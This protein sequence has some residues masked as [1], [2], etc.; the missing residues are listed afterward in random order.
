MSASRVR[1]APAGDGGTGGRAVVTGVGVVAPSGVGAD[2]HWR[3]VLSG[4]RRTGPISLFDATGYP[5]RLG[6]EVAD[7]DPGRYADNRA[8]VQT[9]R[10]THL[11]FAA[12]ALALADAGLPERATDPYGWAVTLASASGGNLFGQR[13][14]QRLWSSPSRTVG[15]YQSIAWF[16][17][18][19]VG[20]LSIRHQAKGPCGVL[21]AE[22]AGGLDSLAHA[23]RTVR[24]GASVVLAGATECPLSPYALACQLRSGLLSEVADPERAY[25]PFD[26]TASGYLPAEGGAVFVVEELEHA[27]ARGARSYGEVTGWGATHDAAHTTADSAGDPHQYA[28]A[29]RL[30]LGRAGVEPDEVDVVVPDAL[31][32]P[33]YDRAEASALRAVFGSRLPPVSTHKELTGRAHQGGSA[34]DVATALLAF[35]HDTL[36]A[37]AGPQVVADGCELDF[38]RA[39]RRPRT[40]VALICARG[41]DGF[42]SALVVRGA[43]PA[44]EEW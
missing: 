29:M 12:T 39:A 27:R 2:A 31:G 19:S 28:R 1:T 8:L 26:A 4:R 23:V 7:F 36:P 3:T 20:Q 38:L 16:Y 5:T 15:A 33:R 30:A 34:L 13:E 21:V 37:S 44:G 32:V 25:R 40:R 18:A 42:N 24:R 41:F 43:P 14:L 6:G 22:S 9:D 17:A 11:G 10:W 35:A